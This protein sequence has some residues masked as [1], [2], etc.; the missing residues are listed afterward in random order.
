MLVKLPPFRQ[1][2]RWLAG[3]LSVLSRMKPIPVQMT[4]VPSSGSHKMLSLI[5]ILVLQGR[6]GTSGK[7]C[8]ESRQILV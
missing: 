8:C 4:T 3:V 7:D 5:T 6:D 1:L 2:K